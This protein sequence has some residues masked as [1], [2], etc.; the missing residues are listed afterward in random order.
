MLAVTTATVSTEMLEPIR[1]RSPFL[2]FMGAI[3]LTTWY[4]GRG[5]GLLSVIFSVLLADYFFIT[6]VSS[7]HIHGWG[8]WTRLGV[9]SGVAWLIFSLT[10]RLRIS[11]DRIQALNHELEQRIAE[12]TK[13][14][15]HANREL[16]E[17]DR[18]KSLSLSVASH[19]FRT[20]LTSIKGSVDNLVAGIAGECNGRIRADLIRIQRNTDRLIR[21]TNNLLDLT[22]LESDTVTVSRESFH[23]HDVVTAVLSEFQ[24]LA[25]SK[26]ITIDTVMSGAEKVY[27][28]RD[29]V[30]EILNNLVH[31]ALKF[32]QSG[33]QVT[34]E[35]SRLGDAAVEISVVDTGRGIPADKL[36]RIF[37][38]FQRARKEDAVHGGAGLGLTIT[39]RLV[40]LQG[41]HIR[42]ES[43]VGQGSRFRF[44]LPT[45]GSSPSA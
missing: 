22:L 3:C 32:T 17:L 11:E 14:L 9:F 42:V 31:N 24:E 38:K 21:L 6:P 37:E 18:R 5:P 8:E 23:V 25:T 29:K 35:V 30:E 16:Q 36:E 1:E 41:G 2:F 26:G 10:Q 15:E 43:I 40:A 44:T 33:G 12:R 34:L 20:P 4:G 13:A 45:A 27:A 28:D 19:E 39:K 7:L